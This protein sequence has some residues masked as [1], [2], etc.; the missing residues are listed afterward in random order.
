MTDVLRRME[1]ASRTY[2]LGRILVRALE[3]ASCEVHPVERIAVVGPSGSGKLTL[4]HLLG[5]IDAPTGVAFPGPPWD[6]GKSCAL[7]ISVSVFPSS[8]LLSPLSV[9]ENTQLPLL[10]MGVG[11]MEARKPA[12]R[13]LVDIGLED[14]RGPVAG[15]AFGRAGSTGCLGAR[16]GIQS[17]VEPRT[18]ATGQSDRPFHRAASFTSALTTLEERDTALVVATHDS[19]VAARMTAVWRVH[20]GKLEVNG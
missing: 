16:P 4:L 19:M 12:F 18:R 6:R 11:Q 8:S 5:G 20:H 7:G 3:S 1:N 9:L 10:L 15:R 17:E 2:A 14:D 13:A